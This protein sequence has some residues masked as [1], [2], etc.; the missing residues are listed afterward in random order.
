MNLTITSFGL[1]IRN[2]NDGAVLSLADLERE[3]ILS[4]LNPLDVVKVL[5]IPTIVAYHDHHELIAAIDDIEKFIEVYGRA[6]IMDYLRINEN[7]EEQ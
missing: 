2:Y 1:T 4:Q 3:E 5:D 6:T 7:D